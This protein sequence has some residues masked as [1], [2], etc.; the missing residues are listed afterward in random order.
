MAQPAKSLRTDWLPPPL[1]PVLDGA[2][3]R[4]GRGGGGGEREDRTCECVVPDA[5]Q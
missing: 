5:S 4:R 1:L 2:G 3:D